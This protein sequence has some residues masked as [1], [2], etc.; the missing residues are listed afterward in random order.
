M[1][2]V[3]ELPAGYPHLPTTPIKQEPQ[4]TEM[5]AHVTNIWMEEKDSRGCNY[6]RIDFSNDYH[7]RIVI[8]GFSPESLANAFK[9]AAYLIF[10]S[11]HNGKFEV[12]S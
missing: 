9:D 5:K 11:D 2:S 12:Q 3:G 1:E 8:D 4:L 6:I 10:K 7:F